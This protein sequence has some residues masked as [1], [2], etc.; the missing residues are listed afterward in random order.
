MLIII[1]FN[2][3]GG[4]IIKK[5]IKLSVV[6]LTIILVFYG[7]KLYQ[8]KRMYEEYISIELNNDTGNLVR[9]IIESNELYKDILNKGNITRYEAER[10]KF[11]AYTIQKFTQEYGFLAQ[12]F[13][14]MKSNE[15]QNETASQVADIAYFYSEMN[16][17]TLIDGDNMDEVIL[18]LDNGMEE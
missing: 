17:E 9:D 16:G 12:N 8:D 3:R 1:Y 10:L 18:V 2:N 6:I 4:D 7:Y 11:N 13:E 14:R 15:F 5:L